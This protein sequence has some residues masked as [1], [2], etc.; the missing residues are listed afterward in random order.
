[1]RTLAVLVGVPCSLAMLAAWIR[2]RAV[3]DALFLLKVRAGFWG[4]LWGTLGYDL[5]RIPFHWAGQNPFPPIRSYGVWISG[6][7][8]S[9]P[10]TDGWGFFYHLSNGITF[11]WIYSFLLLRKHWIW[12]VVW[13]L[14][15]ETVAVYTAFGEVFRIRSAYSALGLAYAAH[16]FYGF[17]LGRLCRNPQKPV[18]PMWT[19]CLLAGVAVWFVTAWQ[20]VTQQPS[21]RA[22][23]LQVGKAAIYPGWSDLPRLS[24]LRIQ[25]TLEEPIR[26][27][28]RTPTTPLNRAQ[29]KILP[30]GGT[31]EITLNERGIYQFGVT[32][33]PWRSVFVSV[34]EDGRYRP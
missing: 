9:T 15:L 26:L 6:G 34:Q 31:S 8:F 29:E 11:G 32:K 17:P 27:M 12:A 7:A 14:L 30:A 10:W 4:G 16:L 28:F 3:G 2:S 33:K 13:G 20:P 22:G 24:S 18:R 25:N 19:L 21:L 5:V 1:M 23:Q